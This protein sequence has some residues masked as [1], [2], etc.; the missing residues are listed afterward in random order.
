[1]WITFEI[2]L[3]KDPKPI[4]LEGRININDSVASGQVAETHDAIRVC[5]ERLISISGQHVSSQ[6]VTG[7]DDWP[8]PQFRMHRQFDMQTSSDGKDES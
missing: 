7:P 1:M 6:I 5:I 4:V 2:T 8:T 3:N